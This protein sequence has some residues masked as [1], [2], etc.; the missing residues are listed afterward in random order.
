M[1][2]IN[3]AMFKL[4]AAGCCLSLNSWYCLCC[5]HLYIN[6]PGQVL[7]LDFFAATPFPSYD[8]ITMGMILHDWG[9]EKKK[10]LMKKVRAHPAAATRSNTTAAGMRVIH[11]LQVVSPPLAR[12]LFC[13]LFH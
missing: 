6:K 5:C 1:M 7:D 3:T 11:V 10:L 8:V 12:V 4:V 9:L 13:V 2:Q